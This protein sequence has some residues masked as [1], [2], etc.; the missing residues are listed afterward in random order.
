MKISGSES[1]DRAFMTLKSEFEACRQKRSMLRMLK[2][3]KNNPLLHFELKL[4]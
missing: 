2:M 4:S 1:V 3:L